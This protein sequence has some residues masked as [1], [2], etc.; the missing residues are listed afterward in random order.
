MCHILDQHG[1]NPARLVPILQAVQEEYRY[2]PQ[3]VL[4]YVATA[5]GVSPARVYGVATFYAHFA[6][7]PKGQA[8]D[9]A[10]RRHGLPREGVGADPARA[11]EAARGG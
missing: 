4:T 7:K 1:R 11:A 8:P 5:L 2:L 6:I 10:V 9:S 3:E